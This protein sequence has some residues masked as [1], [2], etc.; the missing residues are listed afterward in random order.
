MAQCLITLAA[1]VKDLSLADSSQ[2]VA[3]N[4]NASGIAQVCCTYIYGSILV[5]LKK[6]KMKTN[7]H[8]A[9]L[10]SLSTLDLGSSFDWIWEYFVCLSPVLL[11]LERTGFTSLLPPA[12]TS[13]KRLLS[14]SPY[15]LWRVLLIHLLLDDIISL[16]ALNISHM[17]L[18]SKFIPAV[19]PA[20]W[21]LY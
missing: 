14:R 11:F 7:K 10:L 9:L 18:T 20:H 8:L 12:L 16:M 19:S 1:L 4:S 17:P 13:W 21:L 5:K 2:L 6:N 15:C 3:H